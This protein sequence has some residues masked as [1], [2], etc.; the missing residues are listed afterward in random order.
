MWPGASPLGI[1]LKTLLAILFMAMIV[2]DLG[3]HH[4]H[5]RL[6]GAYDLLLRR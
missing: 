3:K 6:A 2:D 1:C 4:F 5:N